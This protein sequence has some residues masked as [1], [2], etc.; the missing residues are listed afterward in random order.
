MKRYTQ[1]RV[2]SERVSDEYRASLGVGFS[3]NGCS[4]CQC[5]TDTQSSM[6]EWPDDMPLAMV[7][8]PVQSFTNIYE[9]NEALSR[10][11]LFSDL[12]FPF[13]AACRGTMR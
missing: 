10:G 7:Y 3:T 8:S 4:D 6:S 1:Y 2:P 5:G 13:E 9:D 11:S 12:Y